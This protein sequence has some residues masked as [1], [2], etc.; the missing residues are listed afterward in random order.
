MWIGCKNGTIRIWEIETGQMLEDRTH[1][2]G[3]ILCLLL[4]KDRVWS[5]ARDKAILI[6]SPKKA[7]PEKKFVAAFK[8]KDIFGT[9][10]LEVDQFVWSGCNDGTIR[11]WDVKNTKVKKE[12]KVDNHGITCMMK[13]TNQVWTGNEL[14]LIH[15]WNTTTLRP[16]KTINAHSKPINSF[17][18]IGPTS[19]PF[20]IWS[21]SSDNSIKCWHAE[22][23]DCVKTL[24]VNTNITC[25]LQVRSVHHVWAGG[26]DSGIYVWNAK[27][28]ELAQ[29][30]V[31][32]QSGPVMTLVLDKRNQIWTG[33]ADG[34]ICI[35]R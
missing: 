30:L 28:Y 8:D 13:R 14:G 32:Q 26:E 5:S 24:A 27:T 34:T 33:S 19:Y 16:I 7:V 4:V 31:S 21:C 6:W 23:Y 9:S 10:M 25:L 11:L 3:A 1:H 35:W 17:T 15:I 2:T 29:E 12:L 18:Y 22:S 20:E